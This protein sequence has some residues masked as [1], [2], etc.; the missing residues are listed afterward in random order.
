MTKH[1]QDALLGYLEFNL[2][3]MVESLEIQ[4]RE[5]LDPQMVTA[6]YDA[7]YEVLNE[8]ERTLTEQNESIPP[9]KTKG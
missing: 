1:E 5:S 2:T 3:S 8:M 4:L 7:A 9:A 6:M